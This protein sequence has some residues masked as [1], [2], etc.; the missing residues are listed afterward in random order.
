[1]VRSLADGKESLVVRADDQAIGGL[2]WSPDGKAIVFSDNNAHDPPRAD[3]G[4]TPARRSS[5]RSART[6]RARRARSPPPAARRRALGPG[7][8]FGGRRWLDARHFLVERTS[9]DFKRR[10]TSLVDIAGGEPKVLHEDVEEKFWSITGDAG[11]AQPSPDGKWIAFLSDRDGWDHLYVMPA[12]RRRRP[13]RRSRKGKFEVVAAAVV[14][15]QHAH[16]VRRERAGSLRRSRISTSRRSAPIR[17]TRRSPPSPAAAA[18]TSR[19]S[20]RPTARGWCISTPIRTTPPTS[21]SPTRSRP[22]S[23][24][25]CPT[26]CRR[27]SIAR[28]SSSP[29]R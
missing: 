3:A 1:M 4:S 26:R 28:R 12:G 5:T 2:S 19:R 27:R 25:G 20:G 23:R 15:R 21:G 9:P 14:A 29:K 13:S 8:G 17:R 11:D 6:C 18:P 10:T 16:R 22:R 7:G 24:R